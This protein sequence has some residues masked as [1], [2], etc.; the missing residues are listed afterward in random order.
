[1]KEIWERPPKTLDEQIDILQERGM[2]LPREKSKKL[3]LQFN[4]AHIIYEYSYIFQKEDK[5]TYK[6]NTR[7]TDLI[8][9]WKFERELVSIILPYI[10]SFELIFKSVMA[11]H[12]AEKGTLA[13]LQSSIYSDNLD[14]KKIKS[15]QKKLIAREN[16]YW[17]Q[18]KQSDRKKGKLPIW[19][20]INQLVLGDLIELYSSLKKAFQSK[21]LSGMGYGGEIEEFILDSHIIRE[22][23]NRASHNKPIHSEFILNPS[24]FQVKKE[25]FVFND[26]IFALSKMKNSRNLKNKIAR[27]MFVSLEKSSEYPKKIVWLSKIYKINIE[28]EIEKLANPRFDS[29]DYTKNKS[30]KRGSNE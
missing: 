21:T 12:I 6:K 22:Y 2:E 20:L 14:K 28:N 5:K 29:K 9:F 7:L 4:Y 16:T 25:E 10:Y 8:N 18:F 17:T 11:Y 1:M 27:R 26:C 3:L 15:M 23:R 24:K 19:I 30:A 13:H